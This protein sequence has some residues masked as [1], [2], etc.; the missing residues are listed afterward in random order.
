MQG[1]I[2]KANRVLT[3][4]YRLSM[5]ERIGR[6]DYA[7]EAG[8]S[9]RS[10]ERDVLEIRTVL[11]DMRNG[12]ELLLDDEGRFYFSNSGPREFTETEVLFIS[13]VLLSSRSL[14]KAEMRRVIAAMGSL[15]GFA[16]RTEIKSAI[17]SEMEQYA[18]PLHGKELLQLHWNLTRA[19]QR[20]V[21]IKICYR[22]ANGDDVN[23]K[24]LPISIVSSEYYLYLV[25]FFEEKAYDY[26]AFFRLDRILSVEVTQEHYDS[27]LFE[28]YNMGK[29]KQC[30][31]FMYAGSL[32]KV[33]LR[34]DDRVL[35][36]VCD[37]LPNHRLLSSEGDWT[38]LQA[39]V[40]GEGFSRWIMQYGSSV[41]VLEP[42]ELRNRIR[43]TARDIWE[44]YQ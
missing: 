34:C 29:M 3:L 8:I 38:L 22:K 23:R 24:V 6:E 31:Q 13:K 4:L 14:C 11:A 36:A 25:G 9:I 44:K 32:L 17:Q 35:E 43:Q 27:S 37:R 33:K 16:V 18:E 30:I 12:Y 2:K 1:R 5:G 40:F 19:M 39:R 20:Q 26:P 42:L 10:A 15:F 7:A 28:G 41:E 21:K